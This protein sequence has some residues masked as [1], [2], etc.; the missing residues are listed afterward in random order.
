MTSELSNVS[1]ISHLFLQKKDTFFSQSLSLFPLSLF[2]FLSLSLSSLTS[3]LT[4]AG[5]L[6]PDMDFSTFH[7]LRNFTVKEREGGA[8]GGREGERAGER[9]GERAEEEGD[10][11]ELESLSVER[12]RKKEK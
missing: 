12:E 7:P 6:V 9:V 4:V 8:M 10:R 2:L 3:N 1:F 11:G 5:I